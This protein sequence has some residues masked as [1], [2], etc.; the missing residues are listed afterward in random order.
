M[1]DEPRDE[2]DRTEQPRAG[3]GL[4]GVPQTGKGH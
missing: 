4:R 3:T 1:S 2:L